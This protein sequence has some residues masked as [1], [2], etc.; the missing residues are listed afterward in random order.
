M[1]FLAIII[2]LKAFYILYLILGI[3]L[4]WIYY[5]YKKENLILNILKNKIFYFFS[6]LIFL[7]ILTYFFNTGCLIY[8][9]SFSCF[10]NFD[11]SIGVDATI[12]MNKHYQLWSKAGKTPNFITENPE[13]YLQNMN[14]L[15]NWINLYFFNK[16]SDFLLGIFLLCL[17]FYFIFSQK[18]QKHFQNNLFKQKIILIYIFL[19]ILLIEWFLNHPALRYGGYVLISLI[20]F[21]PF[22][23]FLGKNQV[24][25]ESK[26][27]KIKVFTLIFLTIII[28]SIRNFS[29][30]YDEMNKY[31][32]N[33]ILRPF[34]YIDD[35]HFRIQKR[36]D[37]LIKNY[38]ICQNQTKNCNSEILEKIRK[39][40]FQKYIFIN[41]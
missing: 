29:R 25:Y 10:D 14:W 31:N 37:H 8:P 4:I 1:A 11:W 28:F 36:F 22:S 13:L 21:V 39:T 6:T 5:K 16:V 41:D 2:S 30:I 38:E 19:V 35:K 33:P 32:Y 40:Y 24:D 26:N 15:S 27:I 17:I 3:P 34:F 20:V 7:V 9:I 12:E 23:Y 18:E